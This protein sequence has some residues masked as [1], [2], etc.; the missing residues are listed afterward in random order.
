MSP[1]RTVSWSRRAAWIS[2]SSPTWC[3][4]VS[5]TALKPSRSR[6]RTATA[7]VPA[8]VQEEGPVGQVGERV[9][10]RVVLQLGLQPDPFGDVPAVEDQPVAVAVDGGL[11]VQPLPRAGADPALDPGGGLLGRTLREVALHLPEDVPE[12]LRVDQFRQPGADQFLGRAAVDAGGGRAHVAEHAG[13]VGDHDDVAGPLDQRAEV[14]LLVRQLLG[15]RQVVQQHDALAQDQREHHSAGDD[16]HETVQHALAEGV[17][18]QPDGADRGRGVRGEGAEGGGHPG[19]P[20]GRGALVAVAGLAAA[21]ARTGP[22]RPGEQHAAGEPARVEQLA[23]VVGVLQGLAGEQGVAEDGQRQRHYG[24]VHRGAVAVPAP[25][26][27]PQHHADQQ[28]VQHRVGQCHGQPER[29]ALVAAGGAGQR[30][31]PTE[32]QQRPGDQPAV[33]G[34]AEPARG[35]ARPVGE[36]QQSEDRGRREQ[37]E[38]VVGERGGGDRLPQH[39][40][41]PAPGAVAEGHHQRGEAEAEPGRALPAARGAAVH[42]AGE[43]GGQGGGGEA[44]VPHEVGEAG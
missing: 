30:Q 21:A 37:Q 10:E 6:K 28:D 3:P 25:E 5:L 18:E 34:E 14:V 29:A 17:V 16:Q 4:A 35:V 38:G 1:L 7:E 8:A 43:G 32:G 27:E 31:A 44:E 23:R 22:G 33:Q 19:G 40:L 20:G 13:R 11:D 12:V 42:Q 39:H 36:Q 9:V 24:G 15:Q 41:V 26:A 2:S